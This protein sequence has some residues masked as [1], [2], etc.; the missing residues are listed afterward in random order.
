MAGFW[1]QASLEPKRQ[2]R[3]LMYFANMP[4]FIAKSTSKP[5]FQVGDS[6]HDFLNYEFHFPG[7]VTWQTLQFKIVDPVQPDSTLSLYSILG[8]AGYTVPS[9]Y[10]QDNPRTISKKGF[11][12]SLGGQIKIQQIGAGSGDQSVAPLETWTLNNPFITT[13]NFGTL[14]YGQDGTVDID[15]TIRYDWASLESAGQ[16]WPTNN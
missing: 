1:S 4:Q 13:C 10:T 16:S 15:V 7:K 2:F 11:V 9:D 8:A 14:D 3:W 5:Q 6:K 12:D